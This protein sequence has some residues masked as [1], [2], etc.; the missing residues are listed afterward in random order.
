MKNALLQLHRMQQQALASR[1]WL[2][3]T[4]YQKV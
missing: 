3:I 2:K 1:L 4:D